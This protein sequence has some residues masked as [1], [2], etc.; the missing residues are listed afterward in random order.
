MLT[1]LSQ[2][3]YISPVGAKAHRLP[4]AGHATFND[5]VARMPFHTLTKLEVQCLSLVAGGK[6]ASGIRGCV[7]ASER[8]IDIIL[9]CA[10]RKLGAKN[11]MHAVARGISIGLIAI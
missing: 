5:Q 7:G 6:S 3:G 10:Q 8:E 1:P 2:T 4:E 9:F 11:R